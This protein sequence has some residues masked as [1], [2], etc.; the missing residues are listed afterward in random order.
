MGDA[1]YPNGFKTN[2]VADDTGDMGLL[3]IVKSYFAA[4]GIDMEIR[5]MD[6]AKTA[7]FVNSHKHDQLA[8]R[9]SIG[10]I[11]RLFVPPIHD[12]GRLTT[13]Q[14]DKGDDYLMVSDPVYDDFYAKAMVTTS[15][16]EIKQILRDCN[17]YVARQHFDIS[18][19]TPM[20]YALY[21]PWLKG[22]NGQHSSISGPDGPQL[23]FFY[24][25]RFWIDQQLKKSMGH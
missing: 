17:E 2:I 24:P 6:H 8:Q 7:D 14:G 25:A 12:L 13:G 11:G 1:G 16:D 18:L 5:T 15:A 23:L 4:V 3:Q 20:Q 21:Q 19:L 22:Y 9:G 10:K